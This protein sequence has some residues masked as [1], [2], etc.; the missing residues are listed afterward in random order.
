MNFVQLM[1][2]ESFPAEAAQAALEVK[3]RVKEAFASVNV[4]MKGGRLEIFKENQSEI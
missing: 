4:R 1:L 2:D 3:E